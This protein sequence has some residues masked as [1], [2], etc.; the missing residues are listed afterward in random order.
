MFTWPV[1]EAALLH[2]I[3]CKSSNATSLD[4]CLTCQAGLLYL[5]GHYTDFQDCLAQLLPSHVQG[6]M[7]FPGGCDNSWQSDMELQTLAWSEKAVR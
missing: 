3:I 7:G 6:H 4:L 1:Q 5:E 2:T